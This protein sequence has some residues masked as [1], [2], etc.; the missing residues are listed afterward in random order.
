MI[1]AIL[2]A[3]AAMVFMAWLLFTLAIYALPFFV[4]LSIAL[5]AHSTGAGVLGAAVFGFFAGVATL[6]AGQLLFAFARTPSVRFA[7]ALLFA[8]PAAVAGFHAVHGIVGIGSSSEIWRDVLGGL[9]A[10][11]VGTIAWMRLAGSSTAMAEASVH[12]GHVDD[13][14]MATPG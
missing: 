12:A 6:A 4:G 8:V 2:L 3:I 11:V 10:I 9:G 7:I 5:W 13:R 14:T 1:I